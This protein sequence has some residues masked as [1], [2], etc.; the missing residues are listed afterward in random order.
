MVSSY[1]DVASRG[2]E[3]VSF[4]FQKTRSQLILETPRALATAH[5]VE[6]VGQ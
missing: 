5:G 1:D 4:D 6:S 3:N 2:W